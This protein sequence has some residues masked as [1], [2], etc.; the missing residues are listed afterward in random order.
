MIRGDPLGI[1][2]RNV[3][4]KLDDCGALFKFLIFGGLPETS[5][6]RPTPAGVNADADTFGTARNRSSPL[7]RVFREVVRHYF[8]LAFSPRYRRES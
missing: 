7:D 8:F 6:A 4:A 1:C 2:P 5:K 3:A